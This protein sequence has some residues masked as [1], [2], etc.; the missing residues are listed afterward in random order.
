M[1]LLCYYALQFAK[2]IMLNEPLLSVKDIYRLQNEM[3]V[4]L[5]NASGM[6]S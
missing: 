5:L 4:E 1:T 3:A 2:A 6:N